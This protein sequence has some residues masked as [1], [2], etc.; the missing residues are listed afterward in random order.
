LTQRAAELASLLESALARVGEPEADVFARAA[1][2]GYARFAVGELGQHM[3]IEEPRAFV[4]VAR[5]KRVAEVSTTSLDESGL[6]QALERAALLAPQVPEDPSFPGF[7]GMEQPEPPA[8]ERWAD[9]TASFSAEQR[10]ELL[11]PVLERIAQA[12]LVATGV[13]DTTT[14]ADAVATSGGLVRACDRTVA[15]FKVWALERSGSGGAAG[16]G[17]DANIDVTR[18]DV[19]RET[20]RAI[21]DA[22]ASKDPIALPAGDYDVVFEP[23]AIT[24]LMEWLG[25]IA[26]GAGELHRG[27]SPLAGRIGDK[28]SGPLLDVFDDPLGALS[29]AAPFD[30]EGVTRRRVPLIERGIARGVL[31][32]RAWAARLGASSTGS[33]VPGASFSEGGPAPAAL[34]LG[35]GE[36]KSSE[37]LVTGV[38][39]GLF[40]RR[41]H[42][43]NGMLDPRRAMMTGL[44]RDGTFL[45]EG[46]KLTRAVG[47]LRFTDSLLEAF[48]RVDGMTRAQRIIPN[49]WSESGSGASPAVRMRK[50]CF[51]SGSQRRA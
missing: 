20:E 41:L 7:A 47:N 12:G 31:Y 30:R 29:F 19:T 37:E 40:V 27:S 14:L 28:I 10:V 26:F 33:A 50:L 15:T 22:L 38:E 23:P 39:R 42:Y 8:L 11:A 1:S 9:A 5:G 2:R 3:H 34:V 36:A 35:G 49:W 4:R 24:E 16:H 25:F 21:A 18:L 48:E 6:V 44:T 46:G 43:V 32:D 17:H 51:T 45:I 13:L